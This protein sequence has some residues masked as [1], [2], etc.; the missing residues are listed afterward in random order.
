MMQKPL[1]KLALA[2]SLL[3]GASLGA[4]SAAEFKIAVVAPQNGPFAVLGDQ[5]RQG[6]T[7]AAR[8]LSI[9]LIEI[10]ETCSEGSGKV[11]ADAI[12]AAGATAAIGFLCS[13]SLKDALP[14][15]SQANVPALTL[16]V[17]WKG[18]MEDAIKEGSPLFRLAPNADQEAAKLSDVILRE[19]AGSAV[20]LLEDGT[21]RGREL[22][23]AIR[24][25]LEERGLKPAFVDTFRP[26][27]EQQ[28]T[29]VRRVK[30]AGITHAFI[31][32][33]RGDVAVIA[34]D[35]K[36]EGLSLT[37]LGG[38]AMRAADEPV[39][40]EDGVL[41]VGLIET[42]QEPAAA[43]LAAELTEAKITPEG[44]VVPAHSAVTILADAWGISSAM[45]TP[46]ADALIGT[47]FETAL[48]PITFGE[49]HELTENP[50]RLLEW[51]GD[52]FVPVP[53]KTQ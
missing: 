1:L 16:S 30:A 52:R 18:L 4:P 42:P 37:L 38:E 12:S 43:A 33:D 2:T 17:R 49:D 31:G 25:S 20:A 14:T 22:T 13:E 19:W 6:A 15:L 32:G 24:T 28:L 8:K 3:L 27:Q 26:G 47:T 11:I 44:Y 39:A 21:I 40:L 10:D 50:Y 29:L 53:G 23:E 45:G 51:Q 48:G 34:R 41:A 35:A 9:T 36:S 5:V 46:V 7:L